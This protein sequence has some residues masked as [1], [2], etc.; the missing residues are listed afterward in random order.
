MADP[1]NVSYKSSSTQ[2]RDK[3]ALELAVGPT[4]TVSFTFGVEGYDIGWSVDFAPDAAAGAGAPEVVVPWERVDCHVLPCHGTI[5]H[6]PCAGTLTLSW[7][8]S[9][10]W[11]RAKLLS[12]SVRVVSETSQQVAK[13]AADSAMASAVGCGREIARAET[14]ADKAKAALASADRAVAEAEAVLRERRAASDALAAEESASRGRAGAARQKLAL[15]LV[16]YVAESG[17]T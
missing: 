3:F 6:L 13:R 16:R 5:E 17:W 12:Y 11:H 8:N 9:Y 10:S 4:S 7:D 15:I 1:G 14:R 2:V